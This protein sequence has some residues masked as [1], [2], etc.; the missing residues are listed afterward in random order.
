M[1]QAAT[2]VPSKGKREAEYAK[3]M[4]ALEAECREDYWRH[5]AHMIL[6]KMET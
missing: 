1:V 3:A 6:V 2:S 4:D 5:R